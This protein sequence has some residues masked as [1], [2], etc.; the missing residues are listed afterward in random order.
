MKTIRIPGAPDSY[1]RLRLRCVACGTCDVVGR[2]AHVIQTHVRPGIVC[3]PC[4]VHMDRHPGMAKGVALA[5]LAGKCLADLV[6]QPATGK[7]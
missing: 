2:R 6:H 7:R 1:P 5:I 3:E 4:L